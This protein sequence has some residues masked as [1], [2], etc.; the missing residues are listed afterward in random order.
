MLAGVQNGY[1]G[2]INE[3]LKGIKKDLKVK[4]INICFTGGDANWILQN[5]SIKATYFKNLTLM[6]IGRVLELNS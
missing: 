3:V 1:P 6:G 5:T 2:M 4:R